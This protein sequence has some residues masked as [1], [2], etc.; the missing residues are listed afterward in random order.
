ML[1]GS[2]QDGATPPLLP[3]YQDFQISQSSVQTR[4]VDCL[5]YEI[6]LLIGDH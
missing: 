1:G 6:Q 2:C 5:L 3:G 4:R